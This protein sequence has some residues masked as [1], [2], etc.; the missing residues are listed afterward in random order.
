[1]WTNWK[2][3]S[4]DRTSHTKQRWKNE[5]KKPVLSYIV[6]CFFF[7][8]S[9]FSFYAAGWLDIC[10]RPSFLCVFCFLH[11]FGCWVSNGGSL[12]EFSR[13]NVDFSGRYCAWLRF[14]RVLIFNLPWRICKN[15]FHQRSLECFSR[16]LLIIRNKNSV[17]FNIPLMI[18][19]QRVF[20]PHIFIFPLPFYH[21]NEV[22][23]HKKEVKKKF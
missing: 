3:K 21:F 17:N 8:V 14:S 2:Y 22:F 16:V 18:F 7:A 12:R 1:M 5:R 4:R 19:H 13:G 9:P 15:I 20:P 6:S 10:W 11:C 23:N